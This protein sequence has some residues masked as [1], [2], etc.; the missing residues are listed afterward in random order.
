MNCFISTNTDIYYN[1]AL[2][3][4]LLKEKSEDF[5]FLWQSEPVVVIGKHQNP[6]KETDFHF[7]VDKNIKIARRLSGGGAVYQDL[8]N[9][10]FTLIK[11]TKE[12]KQI[13]LKQHSKPIYDALIA[14]DLDVEYSKRNDLLIDGKKFSGNAEHV[15][16]NRVLHHG[17]LLYNSDLQIL[18]KV[19]ASKKESYTDKTI[20]SVKSKV[21]N[22]KPHLKNSKS[23]D[24][25]LQ[26]LFETL[27]QS[28]SLYTRILEP[29][30]PNIN[31]LRQ[32]KYIQNA[33]VLGYTPAYKLKKT[34]VIEGKK[35]TISLKV[36]KGKIIEVETNGLATSISQW[37]KKQLINSDHVYNLQKENFKSFPLE[38]RDWYKKI[39]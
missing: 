16:K 18:E 23:T 12:G 10:N 27:L 20:N 33:W 5:F 9:I 24:E 32:N 14:L 35:Y 19:L 8:G 4:F 22:L 28:S 3:E 21:T 11:N 34:F 26:L 25:F 37:F 6:Y 38:Y 13:N 31:L 39:F 1:L 2:E 30:S 17:T 15:Y 7:L 36:K 29:Q